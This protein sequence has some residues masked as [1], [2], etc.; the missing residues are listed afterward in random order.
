MGE[1][2]EDDVAKGEDVQC[3]I[4]TWRILQS[5]WSHEGRCTFDGGFSS[6][7]GWVDG[8]AHPK[9]GHFGHERVL[10]QQDIVWTQVVMNKR[11][12]LSVEVGKSL[13]NLTKYDYLEME[14]ELLLAVILQVSPKAGVHLLHD[15]HRQARSRLKIH[16]EELN[17]SGVA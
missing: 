6:E 9:I 2:G 3:L 4:V 16:T 7:D 5:L 14:G 15:K 12:V 11:R 10:V 17:H 8:S 1:S 13:G